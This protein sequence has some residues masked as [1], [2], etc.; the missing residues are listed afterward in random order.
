[1]TK[2]PLTLLEAADRVREAQAYVG[3][4]DLWEVEAL[5]RRLAA[6][7]RRGVAHLKG[8]GL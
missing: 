1:M 5:L 4:L 8:D 3:G 7:E 6:S 2:K